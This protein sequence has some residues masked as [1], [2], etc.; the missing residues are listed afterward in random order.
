MGPVGRSARAVLSGLRELLGE[1]TTFI[2]S[3]QPHVFPEV[4]RIAV[5]REGRLVALGSP[6]KIAPQLGDSVTWDRS[7]EPP[8]RRAGGDTA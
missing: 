1:A 4:D 6:E 5:L 8:P 3:H 2:I 7:L